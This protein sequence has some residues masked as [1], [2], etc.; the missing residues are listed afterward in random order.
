M[1]I[2]IWLGPTQIRS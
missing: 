2:Q 1:L